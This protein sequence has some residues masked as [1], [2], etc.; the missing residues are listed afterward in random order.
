MQAL[1]Y[2]KH[3]FLI[4]QVS[5]SCELQLQKPIIPILSMHVFF[6]SQFVILYDTRQERQY[7]LKF[8]SRKFVTSSEILVTCHRYHTQQICE[9]DDFSLT[10]SLLS[11][12]SPLFQI[13]AIVSQHRIQDN[14]LKFR[15]DKTILLNCL[16]G[17][18][19]LVL[20]RML[21]L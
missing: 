11:C 16:H 2:I 18:V 9:S 19:L 17:Q 20:I 10:L 7:C 6:H 4:S 3:N 13:F 8:T 15:P 1:T 5:V 14:V 12:T 21:N